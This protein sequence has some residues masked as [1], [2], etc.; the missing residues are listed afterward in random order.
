VRHTTHDDSD[1]DAFLVRAKME[2]IVR[3]MRTL[4]GA[5]PQPDAA[6][7]EVHVVQFYQ[8]PGVLHYSLLTPA[9][10]VVA[11]LFQPRP[12]EVLVPRLPARVSA[13]ALRGIR[14]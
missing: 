1:F 3:R 5:S 2:P 11:Y 12:I 13:W 10:E 7:R 14:P 9:G 4:L 6:D 8:A